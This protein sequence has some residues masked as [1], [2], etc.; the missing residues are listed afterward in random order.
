M[1]ARGALSVPALQARGVAP[2]ERPSSASQR[3]L[4]HRSSGMRR[5]TLCA[6]SSSDRGAPDD[7][8]L[9]AAVRDPVSFLGG[10][11]AGFLALDLNQGECSQRE[12]WIQKECTS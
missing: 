10:M 6:A 4:T 2:L 1:A 3:M 12:G 11:F 8:V 9:A 7:R 5:G